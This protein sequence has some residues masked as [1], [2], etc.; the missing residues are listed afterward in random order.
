M[1]YKGSL[2]YIDHNNKKTTFRNIEY[3]TAACSCCEYRCG[4]LIQTFLSFCKEEDESTFLESIRISDDLAVKG[5]LNM[6]EQHF[7]LSVVNITIQPKDSHLDWPDWLVLIFP[8][9][10]SQCRTLT[11]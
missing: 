1:L 2:G 5:R 3:W 11:P 8:C 9:G 7:I 10:L 4:S 6:Y